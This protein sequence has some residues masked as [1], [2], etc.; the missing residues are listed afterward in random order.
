MKEYQNHPLAEIFPMLGNG[1]LKDLAEDIKATGLQTPIVIF[2]EKILDGRNRYAACKLA[3][4]EPAFER[5]EGSDPLHHIISLNL[6]RR[7]LSESQRAMI[8]G[9]IANLKHGQRADEMQS[10]NIKTLPP[11][12]QKEAATLLN[13]GKSSVEKA[14]R[15][16][17]EAPEKIK[18]IET[19]KK[20]VNKA[21]QEI[22]AEQPPKPQKPVHPSVTVDKGREKAIQHAVNAINELKKIPVN[23][24]SRREAFKMVKNYINQNSKEVV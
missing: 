16:M 6:H 17:R 13:V 14:Q 3:G 7:H 1:E 12:T 10:L 21:M 11:V 18:D 22:K 4:V 23:E 19:G 15:I 20:T 24:E 8:A 5:Y 2:E 9:K